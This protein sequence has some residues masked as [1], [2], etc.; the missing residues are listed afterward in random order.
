MSKRFAM[1]RFLGLSEEEIKKNEKLWGEENS[2][3]NDMDVNGS[4]LRN[5]G[6]SS[7]DF[8][9]DLNTA[10]EIEDQAPEEGPEVAG[11]VTGTGGEAV[12]GGPAGPVGGGGAMQ[13]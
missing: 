2:E 6:I 8:E 1:E 11:P 3:K 7:G 10:D 13:I 5:I 12:P 9:T 4:D